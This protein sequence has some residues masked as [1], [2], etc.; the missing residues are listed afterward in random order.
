[1]TGLGHVPDAHT[2]SADDV[3]LHRQGTSRLRLLDGYRA[4]AALFV[5]VTHVGFQTG[6]AISGPFAGILSRLD[7][8]VTIFFL[9]SGFLLVR[10]FLQALNGTGARPALREYAWHRFLRIMPAYWV[11]V[12]AAL[13]LLPAN[14]SSSAG[15]WTVQLLV[16]QTYIPHQLLDGLT[17][18]W[19]LGAEIAFYVTL[20]FLGW[21]L[22]YRRPTSSHGQRTRFWALLGTMVAISTAWRWWAFTR[23]GGA[24]LLPLWLPNYLYGGS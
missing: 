22:T 21:L 19:S 11:A 5:L 24:G 7:I 10:P 20:P 12:I 2:T 1:M 3:A 4:L 23:V 18:M 6:A 17:Q 8:G 16:L 13:V 15:T 9:L 14:R